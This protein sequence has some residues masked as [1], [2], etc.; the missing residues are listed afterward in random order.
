VDGSTVYTGQIRRKEQGIIVH[1]EAQTFTKKVL[2]HETAKD[3]VEGTAG[4][5]RASVEFNHV[6]M[7]QKMSNDRRA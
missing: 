4:V 3:S 1:T 2:T 5:R 6:L 7:N